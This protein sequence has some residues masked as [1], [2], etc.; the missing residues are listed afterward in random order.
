MPRR[1]RTVIAKPNVKSESSIG[2]G[3]GCLAGVG[4][5]SP[6]NVMDVKTPDAVPEYDAAS[7]L[8]ISTTNQQFPGSDSNLPPVPHAQMRRNVQ[9][10][11]EK[12]SEVPGILIQ[13]GVAGVLKFFL[14]QLR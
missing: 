10:T 1:R 4:R 12:G 11:G 2:S 7:G 14:R 13:M 8:P 6:E 3:T 5:L 9:F